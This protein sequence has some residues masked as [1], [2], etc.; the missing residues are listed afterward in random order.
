MCKGHNLYCVHLFPLK[1]KN[2][3]DKHCVKIKNVLK[4]KI[5]AGY[6]AIGYNLGSGK[7]SM[8]LEN[9]KPNLGNTSSEGPE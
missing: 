7:L 4:K 2:T 8:Q 9:L 6:N 3:E 5:I 1:K